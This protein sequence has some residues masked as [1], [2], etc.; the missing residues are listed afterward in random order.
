MESANDYSNVPDWVEKPEGY[1]ADS[2]VKYQGHIFKA[3]FWASKPGDGDPLKNGWRLY[4]ELYDITSTPA[5]GPAR[6]IGYIPTWRQKEGFDYANPAMYRSITH[7]IISFLMFSETD[8]GAFDPTSVQDVKAVLDDVLYTGHDQGTYISIALGGAVD[9]G[10]LYLMERIGNN[11]G[12]PVLQKAVRLVVDF[13]EANG[14]DGVDLDLECWWD[15]N[16]DASKDQG[17]RLKS[18]GPHAA[19]KG[20]TEFANQL[21][22]AMPDKIISAALFASSW[23][24]NCYDPGLV[25]YVDWLGLMT[26]DLTGSWSQ[27][28]VGPHTALVKIRDQKVYLADQQGEWPG[29]RKSSVDT[30]DPTV[31]N[32]ILSVEDSL[33]YWTNPFFTNWQGEGQNIPR[34]KI[35]AGVPIYGYDFA[36]GKDPDDLSG[37]I[38]PGYKAVRYKDI[39]AQ[40]PDALSAPNA[41]INVPGS[42]PRPPFVPAGG[43]Y[44][45]AHNIYF[46]TPDTAVTKLNFMQRIGAQGVIIWELS[47]DVLEGGKSIVQALYQNSGHPATRPALPSKP[48]PEPEPEPIPELDLSLPFPPELFGV[49]PDEWSES[50]VLSAS[51]D[52]SARRP[53]LQVAGSDMTTASFDE[54]SRIGIAGSPAVAVFNGKLYSVYEGRGED[55]WLWFSS[56]DGQYWSQSTKL[57]N[58]GTSGPPAVAVH[59]GK[60]CCVHEGRAEDGWLW[61]CSFDGQN[62]SQSTKLSAGTASRRRSLPRAALAVYK[63][64]LYCVHQGGEGRENGS[65]WV[66]TF[67]GQNW[68]EDTMLPNHFTSGGPALVVVNDLLVCMHEAP[69]ETGTL[70]ET[71]FNGTTWSEDNE[72]LVAGNGYGTSGPPALVVHNGRLFCVHEGVGEDGYVWSFNRPDRTDKQLTSGLFEKK[73]IGTSGPPALTVYNDRFMLLHE[74]RG[75]DGYLWGSVLSSSDFPVN[76]SEWAL[77][78]GD[79]AYCYSACVVTKDTNRSHAS[80]HT[81][82]VREG[83]PFLY[84]VLT[85][86]DTSIDFPTGTLLTIQGPDGTKYD[87]SADEENRLVIMSGSSVRCLII[88][89]PRPGNWQMTMSGLAGVGFHCEC[90]TVPSRDVY[91][92]I[93]NAL[94]KRGLTEDTAGTTGWVGPVL[95]GLITAVAA[96]GTGGLDPL[97]GLLLGAMAGVVI[98]ALSGNDPPTET[99]TYLSF[100][101]QI[102]PIVDKL[103]ADFNEKG[104]RETIVF[105][106]YLIGRNLSVQEWQVILTTKPQSAVSVILV[107]AQV[108]K[109]IE[110]MTDAE[111]Q[112]AVRHVLWQC[113]LKQRFGADFATKIGEAHEEARP[114]SDADN[115]ADEINNAIGQKLADEVQSDLECFRRAQ[116]LWDAGE[117]QIRTDL[118]GDP[119]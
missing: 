50:T 25:E 48:R 95:V 119:N 84:A 98:W 65:M 106:Y 60:L 45:F 33:W 49:F 104:F 2:M 93:T 66:S 23:Y 14:L 36:Y 100:V 53:D 116:E 63:G 105:Y 85:K 41:N 68:S 58:H 91:S 34:N 111:E 52:S 76:P 51:Q 57:P 80:R 37:Q 75:K 18:D 70:M 83:A 32:P 90:G 54:L 69:A 96:V 22:Q 78:E 1:Q 102:R 92:T 64:L 117:L 89:N 114:G 73:P 109:I 16:S 24:G 59:D 110:H 4:D 10:F 7:G 103:V 67:D 81:M 87:R 21:R 108:F 97:T 3:D 44:P 27:S 82:N 61:F 28:P 29:N 11:P 46:E 99:A 101:S 79:N 94:S 20:L 31:D 15:K 55:G 74:G 112:N 62:W 42:T 19:G 113:L 17:G 38:A 6:I 77:S 35:A 56:F 39:L 88:K 9:Y 86:D 115:R 8:L 5:T 12:D 40:F 47:N 43:S 72:L 107:Y 26:Y 13:V 30:A 118:G 71:R